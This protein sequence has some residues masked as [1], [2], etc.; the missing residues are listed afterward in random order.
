MDLRHDLEGIAV[1]IEHV[2]NQLDEPFRQLAQEWASL[3]AIELLGSGP[4]R[5]TAAYGAAKLLEAVG[6][7]ATHQDIEEW[8]HLEY[9]VAD[10]EHTG[11]ILICP[12]DSPALSRAVEVERFL[13]TLKRPYLVLSGQPGATAFQ[14]VLAPIETVRP[15]FAPL[16]YSAP[17][18]L[19][20]AHLSAQAGAT[21]GRGAV[22]QWADCSDGASTRNSQIQ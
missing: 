18:A 6:A 8:V 5:A 22:G 10:A 12:S 16:L 3:P 9:F 4:D 17:L 1:A 11:T 20:A 21:Y 7:H 15:V 14:Q 19:F 2:I 13:R